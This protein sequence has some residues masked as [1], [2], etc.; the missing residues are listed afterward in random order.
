MCL[1][2]ISRLV[3]VW[4]ADG[5]RVGRLEGGAVVSLLFVPEAEPGETV[6]LH[7]GVPVEV[8]DPAAAADALTLR[9]GRP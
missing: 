5:A 7:L 2:T 3:E 1:G 6:L 8:L 4:D 9:G